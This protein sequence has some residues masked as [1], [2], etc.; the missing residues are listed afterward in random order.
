MDLYRRIESLEKL[1]S[2]RD[3]AIERLLSER[4]GALS[5]RMAALEGIIANKSDK[6]ELTAV[7]SSIPPILR[8]LE[9]LQPIF[10]QISYLEKS[11]KKFEV[12]AR[13]DDLT[14]RINL[15]ERK[16]STAVEP[17]AGRFLL[18]IDLSQVGGYDDL[19]S[20][21]SGLMPLA[22]IAALG[23]SYTKDEAEFGNDVLVIPAKMIVQKKIWIVDFSVPTDHGYKDFFFE[24]ILGKTGLS[25]IISGFVIE[26]G[27]FYRGLIAPTL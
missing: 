22:K 8:Q 4:A 17:V 19:L 15:F 26:V 13:V 5:E 3:G 20:E 12:S 9:I 16:S 11:V 18:C 7:S 21:S 10:K 2:E 1:V 27:D 23:L 24:L 14:K 6:S 25:G